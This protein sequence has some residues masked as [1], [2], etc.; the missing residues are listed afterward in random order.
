[1]TAENATR[2]QHRPAGS[3]ASAGRSLPEWFDRLL[4][5]DPGLIR[6][7]AALQ[8]VATIGVAILAEWLFVRF[9][10]ALQS[11]THGAV[12][13]PAQ[14]ALVAAQHHGVVVIAIMLG[15]IIAMI[16]VFSASLFPTPRALLT[17]FAMMP[18]PMIAG[19]CL[20]LALAPH[21]VV[22][23]GMFVVVLIG[24]AYC[25][26]FAALGFVGGM[27]LFMGDFFGFFLNGEVAIS[28]IGWLSVE[29]AIGALVAIIA[30]FTLFYP[31]RRMALVRMR[32]SYSVRARGVASAAL[33]F[34]DE[35][36]NPRRASRRLHRRLIRL[37]ET[38]LMIDAQLTGP[39]S[40]PAGWS[41]N[42][43]HQVVFDSELA[44]TN[45]ARFAEHIGQIELPA[46]LREQVHAALSAVG[47]LDLENAELT[48]HELLDRMRELPGDRLSSTDVAAP[49]LDATDR[50]VLHRFAISVLGFAEAVQQWHVFDD[51]SAPDSADTSIDSPVI[52]VGGW[53]PG[54]AIVSAAA[55]MEAGPRPREGGPLWERI[56]LGD[57]VRMAPYTR[58]AIQMGVAV[59]AALLLGDL[60]SGQRFYWAI[61]AAFVAFMGANNSGE[62]VR[63]S[64]FRVTG[65]A[66]GVL[67]GATLAHLV[68]QRTGLAITVIL[69]SLLV[70]LYLMRIS[71]AF[72][73]VGVTVMVS[74]LY[75][76]LDE[77]SN[78]L[79]I[80]RLEETAIGAAAASITVLFVL[81]LHTGRVARVAV[82]QYLQTL[83]DVAALGVQRMSVSPELAH[84]DSGNAE[85]RAMLRRLDLAY[86]TLVT[87][88]TPLRLS[89]ARTA[90]AGG[91]HYLHRAAA[92]RHYARNLLIDTVEKAELSA[93]SREQLAAAGQRLTASLGELAASLQDHDTSERTYVRSASLFDVV[94]TDLPDADYAAP[95]QLALRD[96][97]L[98]DGV[99]AALASSEGLSVVALD[100]AA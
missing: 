69:V 96:L 21:R 9:T 84:G 66:F 27:L 26:R 98:I 91:R 30:Q 23:L 73:V 75:V 31:S 92:A 78:S 1:M 46:A 6:I 16:A 4:G 94:A 49:A 3:G 93:Q 70:G 8:A 40:L 100:T 88:L 10:H 32:R 86:Q 60:L 38:A 58:V 39:G 87:T 77:F 48:G 19:L 57:R 83:S 5:S 29:I 34:L 68:G 79:L 42:E 28:G 76:Q 11:D 41:A 18:I 22:S 15:A 53:L 81:P 71:Y 74:Q 65:T 36:D 97:Q 55:S 25:R 33:A 14:A 35:P 2:E 51:R 85:L 62:Q 43:L 24:G 82:R 95:A 99:M 7:M 61:I 45:I 37:N 52:L 72:M 12:L 64:V 67:L 63:K 90:D 50:I 54:S 47:G 20:G 80:M 56:R 89:P 17:T 59:T 13:P 44:L